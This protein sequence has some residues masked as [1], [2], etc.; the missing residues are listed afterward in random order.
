MSYRWIIGALL[1]PG[2]LLAQN[3][4]EK[5]GALHRSMKP[6]NGQWKIS[7][8]AEMT[9]NGNIIEIISRKGTPKVTKRLPY[10]FTGA[11]RYLQIRIISGSGLVLPG[12]DLGPLPDWL[13]FQPGMYTIPVFEKTRPDLNGKP[14][15]GIMTFFLRLLP[16]KL[17]FSELALVDRDA[18]DGV[19]FSVTS[20]DGKVKDSEAAAVA[21]DTI[22]IEMQVKDKPDNLSLYLYRINDGKNWAYRG[23]FE[24][25]TL[26]GVP[27]ELKATDTPNRYRASFKLRK[28]ANGLKI[29]GGKLAAAVNYLGSDSNNRGYYYGFCAN[30]VDLEADGGTPADRED[31][32]LLVFDFGP[33]SG[34]V[35]PDALAI[36]GTSG[37]PSFHWLKKPSKYVNGFR[38]SLDPLMMDWAEIKPQ[39]YAELE[40]KVKPGKYQVTVGTG[41]ANTMCWL[42][43][44]YR[45]MQA[46][47]LVNGEK[48]WS[49][50][51]QDETRF[52]LMN[53]EV[54]MTDDIY[55]IYIAPHLK[56]LT[57]QADCPDGK[58]RIKITA[59]QKNVPLNYV[60]V[61]PVEDKTAA[62]I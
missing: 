37:H 16:G 28:T 20:P 38:K 41:G 19:F 42:H 18:P 62:Y 35:A 56:D 45:P 26:P 44:F 59:G 4:K 22:T 23:R 52:S 13:K 36:N 25:L 33:P 6:E 10:D 5:S 24:A 46:E 17:Q 12:T 11:V 21:G 54:R 58:L 51:E 40:L 14:M 34:S 8:N 49:F 48:K 31:T 2:V 30:P 47:I 60:A 9:R 39:K 61:Y 32:S 53:R 29:K 57:A 3:G 43:Q 50:N 27:I 7:S 15:K 55:D 1:L